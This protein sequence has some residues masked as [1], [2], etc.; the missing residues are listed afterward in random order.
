MGEASTTELYD[1]LSTRPATFAWISPTLL[2]VN[3]GNQTHRWNVLDKQFHWDHG[4][5]H[6][7]LSHGSH[8]LIVKDAT[9]Q[10][11]MVTHLKQYARRRKTGGAAPILFSRAAFLFLVIVGGL[12]AAY[13]WLMPIIA[14][15][16]ALRL[17]RS[18]DDQLGE[19][20]F[21]AMATSMA[22]DTARTVALQRFGDA[23]EISKDHVLKYHVVNDAQVNAFAM[24]GGHI[25][26]YTGL[27]DEL[28][29]PQELAGLLA[30]EGTHVQER[31]ST[32]SMVRQFASSF[33]LSLVAGDAGALGEIAANK[34]DELRGLSYSRDLEQAADDIGMQRMHANGVDPH[35]MIDLLEELKGAHGS[36]A[37]PPAFLSSHPLTD[38]RIANAKARASTLGVPTQ[39]NTRLKDLFG[40]VRK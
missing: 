31:H 16:L 20:S 7:R 13:I 40:A 10:R 22:F 34:G 3:A 36:S 37:E 25:V 9:A 15:H 27:L 24:P 1:G 33:F 39:A 4:Q 30:H 2:E 5:H 17:P 23:L 18:V 32:R 21:N 12:V 38:D 11:L 6:L 19:A 29:T 8:A 26:V 14:E 28:D 35:G